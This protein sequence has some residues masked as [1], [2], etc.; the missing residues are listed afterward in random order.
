MN[1][2]IFVVTLLSALLLTIFFA[3][4]S[5]ASEIDNDDMGASIVKCFHPTAAYESIEMDNKN[6]HFSSSGDTIIFDGKVRF[7]GGFTGNPYYMKFSMEMRKAG[8]DMEVRIIPGVD[9]AP[10]PPS[11]N[12]SYR[13]WQ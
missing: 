11:P 7:R 2:K 1:N 3:S 5:S 10:F 8:N 13:H 9:T 12:C 4:L 6:L